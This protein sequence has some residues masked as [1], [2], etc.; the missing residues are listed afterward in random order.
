MSADSGTLRD[1]IRDKNKY[2][3]RIE[4]SIWE[5]DPDGRCLAVYGNQYYSNNLDIPEFRRFADLT[6]WDARQRAEQ[7]IATALNQVA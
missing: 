2:E 3:V 5:A 7:A 1:Y 4:V 6:F